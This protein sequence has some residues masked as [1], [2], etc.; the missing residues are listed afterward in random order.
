MDTFSQFLSCIVDKTQKRLLA[1]MIY[2]DLHLTLI[3]KVATWRHQKSGEC[4]AA[5]VQVLLQA[6]LLEAQQ[7]H[8][9]RAF[10]A[11]LQA[12][13]FVCFSLMQLCY[14]LAAGHL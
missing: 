4:S 3:V 7:K 13:R 6:W 12:H 9:E 5:F 14:P 1:P 11:L 10:A 8:Q 2:L